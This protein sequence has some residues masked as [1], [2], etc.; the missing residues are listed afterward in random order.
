MSATAI[1]GVAVAAATLMGVSCRPS[2]GTAPVAAGGLRRA[3]FSPLADSDTWP[4]LGAIVGGAIVVGARGGM[5]AID[6]SSG[7]VAWHSSVF[8]SP[9]AAAVAGNVVVRGQVACIADAPGVGCVDAQ[10]GRVL[11]K[12]ASDSATG[13]LATSAAD[14]ESLYFGT[15]QH[16]VVALGLMDASNRPTFAQVK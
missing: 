10:T 4:G 12:D 6:R 14:D 11:W 5:T 2:D 7:T 8:G 3:W 16:T 1:V 9:Q 15:R 13:F